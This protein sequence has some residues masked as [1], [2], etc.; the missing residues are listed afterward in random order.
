[1]S[2]LALTVVNVYV[3][4]NVHNM[5]FDDLHDDVKSRQVKF[6]PVAFARK[7]YFN[8]MTVFI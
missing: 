6:A 5:K 3:N 2:I 4:T 8:Y 1:V 7:I